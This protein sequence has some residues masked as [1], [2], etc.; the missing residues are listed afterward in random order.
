M[1]VT[2]YHNPGCGTSRNTLAMIP[3]Y[4][5]RAPD[6]Q[7]PEDPT[8]PR[9]P[10]GTGGADGSA[11]ASD[12]AREGHAV[13]RARAGRSVD[14]RRR[15]AGRDRGAPDPDEPAD[16]GHAERRSALPA[17]RTRAEPAR[18]P[19][20]GGLRQ[21]GRRARLGENRS[22]GRLRP[23]PDA[24]PGPCS[25]RGPDRDFYAWSR[26]RPP[27]P[28]PAAARIAAG[29]LLLAPSC[30]RGGAAAGR[31]GMRDAALRPDGPAAAGRGRSLAPESRRVARAVTVVRR[32]GL[33]QPRAAWDVVRRHEVPDRLVAAGAGR[34]PTYPRAARWR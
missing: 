25:L 6:H 29:A 33:E 7:I 34:R 10:A 16:R 31:D 9:D 20:A 12:S 19:A 5:R 15:A 28:H 2:I 18:R 23:V 26:V 8:A 13:R 1:S 4:G 27:A 3:R 14:L 30:R 22:D 24:S 32:A 17:F 11:F 21:G